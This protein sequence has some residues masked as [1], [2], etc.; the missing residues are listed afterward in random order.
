MPPLPW[1]PVGMA[2]PDS[3]SAEGFIA[4][5][6]QAIFDVLADPAKHAVIDG[7]G[8]VQTARTHERLALG[9]SFGMSMRNRISYKTNPVVTE[10]D[11]GR[12]VAWRNK[13]GPTWRYELFP[14]DGGTRV[15]ETYDLS[16]MR[17]GSLMKLTGIGKRAQQNMSKTLERLE[18]LVTADNPA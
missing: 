6:A 1:Q 15:V 11:D 7:S 16:T 4:A 17:G 18:R 5:P 2:S 3:F 10:F 13:G 8:T 14:A 9:A 12:V